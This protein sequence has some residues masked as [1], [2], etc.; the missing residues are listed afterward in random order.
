MS[1]SSIDE[2]LGLDELA[3]DIEPDL[4]LDSNFSNEADEEDKEAVWKM[5]LAQKQAEQESRKKNIDTKTSLTDRVND[6][7][8]S[9]KKSSKK[10]FL[11]L[12]ILLLLVASGVGLFLLNAKYGLIK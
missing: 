11:I 5:R 9:S 1:L 8:E 4:S 6:T 2:Q 12:F 7:V 10:I 3:S